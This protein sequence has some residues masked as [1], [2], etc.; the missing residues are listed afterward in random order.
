MPTDEIENLPFM[1]KVGPEPLDKKTEAG[2]FIK[3]IRRTAKFD[4]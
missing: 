2:D 1:Q 4:D 3:R